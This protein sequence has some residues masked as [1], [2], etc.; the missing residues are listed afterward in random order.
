VIVEGGLVQNEPVLPVFDLDVLKADFINEDDI[1]H[2]RGLADRARQY[3][4]ARLAAR[5][6][7]FVQSET[8]ER[9]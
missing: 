1:S 4:L 6:D 3:G 5:I 7:R 2:A 8:E 9:R